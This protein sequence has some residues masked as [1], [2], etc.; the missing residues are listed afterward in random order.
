MA[1]QKNV[2]CATPDCP[3]LL[4]EGA[5]L[6]K[7]RCASCRGHGIY[8]ANTGPCADPDCDRPSRTK[9][10]CSTHYN[11]AAGH[12]IGAV[13][14]DPDRERARLRVKTHRRKDWSRLTDI[15]PEYEMGLRAKAKR[16]PLCKVKMTDEPYLAHSK[17][18]DHIIP[19][20]AGG[21]HTIGNVRIICR[22][23]NLARPWD[24]SDY[25]GPVTLWAETDNAIPTSPSGLNSR[26]GTS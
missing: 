26:R 15:T 19:Q 12:Y 8:G 20:G 17:E 4:W 2:P 21:T 7:S 1:R 10:L 18:L 16:C 13:E 9:G 24:G 3:N 25:I 23:C 6:G 14:K 22:A 11:K 5:V